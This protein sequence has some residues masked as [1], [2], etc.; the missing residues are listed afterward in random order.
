MPEYK[1]WFRVGGTYFFTIVTYNR[2]K[3]FCESHART[4]LRLAMA[5][6]QSSHPF[7]ILGVV[8]L[9]DHCHCIWKMADNDDNFSVRW[10][11][12]KRRFTKLWLSSG[13]QDLP[14]SPSRS[15]RGERAFGKEGSGNT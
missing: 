2:R 4:S 7:D 13:G 5:Q 6:V 14:V 8:L 15:K 9:P 11:M 12:I 10:R 3:I 1:R